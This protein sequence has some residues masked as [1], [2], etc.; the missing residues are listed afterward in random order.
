MYRGQICNLDFFRVFPCFF[1]QGQLKQRG[2]YTLY[3]VIP[4]AM[5][6][7][8]ESWTSLYML[9]IPGSI[10]GWQLEDGLED[11]EQLSQN[12]HCP[13]LSET[14]PWPWSVCPTIPAYA[15]I[16]RLS[17]HCQPSIEGNNKQLGQY[18]STTVVIL[19]ASCAYHYVYICTGKF[20]NP[21]PG[22]LKFSDIIRTYRKKAAKALNKNM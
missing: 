15:K 5:V 18:L 1:P 22:F 16:K 4:G 17:S 13:S 7:H 19:H 8:V 9:N 10:Q 6:Y 3:T 14:R 20:M 12:K 11:S 21:I 2:H